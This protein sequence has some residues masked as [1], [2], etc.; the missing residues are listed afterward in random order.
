MDSD[1]R[2]R[3]HEAADIIRRRAERLSS[4]ST[5][6]PAS[7]EVSDEDYAVKIRANP[8][9]A[10]HARAFELGERHPLNYPNQR[11]AN[12]WG[13]TPHRPFLELAVDQ[14]EGRAVEKVAMVVEDWTRR[15]G[16]K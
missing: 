3:L 11:R 15:L 6:I 8:D 12:R 2:R 16:Y 14:E 9:V 4:W 5:R 10:P 1:A 7:L 13:N